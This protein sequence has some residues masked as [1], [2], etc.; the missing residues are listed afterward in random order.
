MRTLRT[1]T[2]ERL[3][4]AVD[5]CVI[6]PDKKRI[7]ERHLA[8]PKHGVTAEGIDALLAEVAE[9]IEKNWPGVDYAV[10][11]LGAARF[12]FVPRFLHDHS[13]PSKENNCND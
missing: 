13:S 2:G 1:Q 11:P 8:P 9:K 3:F 7:R 6:T 12:N 5:I 4:K 10:V